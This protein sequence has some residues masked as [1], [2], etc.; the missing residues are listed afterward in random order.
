MGSRK[1]ETTAIILLFLIVFIL[2]LVAMY[3]SAVVVM[4]ICKL[5]NISDKTYEIA[6]IVVINSLIMT[7][8]MIGREPVE[9]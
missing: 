4:F 7:A 5:F 3:S 1:K 9:R 6:I 2:A 8:T